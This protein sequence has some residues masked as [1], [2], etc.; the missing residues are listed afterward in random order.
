VA[1]G[2]PLAASEFC[3]AAMLTDR[4]TTAQAARPKPDAPLGFSDFPGD[5]FPA[6]VSQYRQR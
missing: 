5:H 2:E 1:S 6:S 4:Q 3:R